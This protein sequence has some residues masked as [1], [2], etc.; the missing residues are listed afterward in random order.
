[1]LVDDTTPAWSLALD[2]L[3]VDQ[4]VVQ[5]VTI[6]SRD[7]EIFGDLVGDHAAVHFDPQHAHAMGYAGPIVHGLLLASRFSRLMGMYLPGPRSVIQGL[8]LKF[9]HAVPVGKPITFRNRVKS[10]SPAVG[11]VI[12]DLS[13]LIDDAVSVSAVGTCVFPP[14]KVE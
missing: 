14:P 3:K 6:S 9:V 5:N 8:Q 1:V 11:A 4:E 2:D 10:I 7:V 12:L 13:A